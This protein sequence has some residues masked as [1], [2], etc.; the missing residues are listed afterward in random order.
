M[1]GLAPIGSAT[2]ADFTSAGFPLSF[3][4]PRVSD[5]NIS[6]WNEL[7]SFETDKTASVQLK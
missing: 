2:V 1:A 6:L 5:L 4:K 7:I 3:S